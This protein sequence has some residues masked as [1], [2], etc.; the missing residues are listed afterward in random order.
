M[1]PFPNAE[2]DLIQMKKALSGSVFNLEDNPPTVAKNYDHEQFKETWDDFVVDVRVA[3][4]TC[5]AYVFFYYSGHGVVF[6]NEAGDQ[7]LTQIVHKELSF[8]TLTPIENHLRK[9]STYKNV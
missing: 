4:K 6:A 3:A 8:Q 7:P 2:L 5:L 9:L 1:L